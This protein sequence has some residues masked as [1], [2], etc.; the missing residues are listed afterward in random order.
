MLS[1]GGNLSTLNNYEERPMDFAKSLLLKKLED[2]CG[3]DMRNYNIK[4]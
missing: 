3:G 2:F 1:K 4:Q